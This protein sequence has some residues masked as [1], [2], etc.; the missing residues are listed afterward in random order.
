[1][2]RVRIPISQFKAACTRMLREVATADKLIEVTRHGRVVALVTPPPTRPSRTR[3]WGS[4][5]GTSTAK[6]DLVAPAAG[7]KDWRAAQ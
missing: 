5:H 2:T 3:F 4:M 1:M 7:E 6:D